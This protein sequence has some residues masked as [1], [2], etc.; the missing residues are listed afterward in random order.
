[1]NPVDLRSDTVTRPTPAMRAAMM[2][3]PLG[4][5]VFGDDPSVNALQARIAELTGKEAALFMSSGTQSNL[6]GIR[7]HCGRGDEYIVGQLAHTYRYE[8]GGAAVLGSVQPQPLLQDAQGRMALADIE[9]AIKPDDPHFARTRLLC[10][11]NTWNGHVMPDAYLAEATALARAHGLATHLEIDGDGLPLPADVQV[12]V[13]H[14]VQEALSNV[15]KHA[16]ASHVSLDVHKGE[17]WR[18]VVRD[19]GSGFD[20]AQQRGETHVGTKI[21]RERADRIGAT[22]QIESR[23]GQGTSVTL[24]LPTNPVTTVGVGTAGLD[25]S[26]SV[27][28]TS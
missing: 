13:L 5:D 1:M 21:M 20:T 16:G 4:D 28:N 11:E 25:F 26:D 24:T 14:V 10:L 6:C 7:A 18:F 3:A 22:V 9:A 23:S 17:Q 8:G 2:A 12:Q 15:R 27:L 19:N